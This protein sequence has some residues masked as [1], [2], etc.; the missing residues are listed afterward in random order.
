ME[1]AIMDA[2]K[3]T[4]NRRDER[5]PFRVPEFVWHIPFYLGLAAIAYVVFWRW[6]PRFIEFFE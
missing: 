3:E 5:K 1:C 4:P 2:M 6:L